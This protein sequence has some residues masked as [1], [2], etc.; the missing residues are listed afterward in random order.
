MNASFARKLEP[1]QLRT[2]TAHERA[3][4]AALIPHD[5]KEDRLL[6]EQAQKALAELECDSYDLGRLVA[7]Q[8]LHRRACAACRAALALLAERVGSTLFLDDDPEQLLHALPA[9]IRCDCVRR[10][11]AACVLDRGRRRVEV[12]ATH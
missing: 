8:L 5:D 6:T 2:D 9:D 7:R 1:A 4:L 11:L 10:T 3:L 12:A